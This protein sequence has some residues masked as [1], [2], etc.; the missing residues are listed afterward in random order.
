MTAGAL[1]LRRL[2]LAGSA[3]LTI[4]MILIL[5]WHF[6]ASRPPQGALTVAARIEHIE[7]TVPASGTIAPVK[8]VCAGARASGR[9]LALHVGLGEEAYGARPRGSGVVQLRNAICA[10]INS[11]E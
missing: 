7:D 3:V 1:S 6:L 11:S 8:L 9:V 2:M 5:S 4:A 10:S